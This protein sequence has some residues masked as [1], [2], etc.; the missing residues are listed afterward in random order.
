MYPYILLLVIDFLN[1]FYNYNW[2][3]YFFF[4]RLPLERT[5]VVI[6][7]KISNQKS[8]HLIFYSIFIFTVYEFLLVIC[9]YTLIYCTFFKLLIH[10]LCFFSL[11][12]AECYLQLKYVW[13]QTCYSYLISLGSKEVVLFYLSYNIYMYIIFVETLIIVCDC[14]F[15]INYKIFND[16]F[17]KSTI[18]IKMSVND[19]VFIKSLYSK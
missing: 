7:N 13:I 18:I 17:K 1:A 14:T 11:T 3:I 5:N 19:T 12:L 16:P 15:V 2:N 6:K 10:M 8:N 4:S 9:K